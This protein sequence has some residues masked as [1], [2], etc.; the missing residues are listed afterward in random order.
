MP[1]KDLDA[2]WADF[3]QTTQLAA[4]T[5][6]DAAIEH[7]LRVIF[8][9]G[10]SAGLGVVTYYVAAGDDT[11]TLTGLI[12]QLLKAHDIIHADTCRTADATGAVT[13][14]EETLAA[15]QRIAQAPIPSGHL[16]PRRRRAT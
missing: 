5:G 1:F 12:G 9:A 10:A 16:P 2:A 11:L 7:Y 15:L 4:L 3:R 13:T 8:S 14:T 6:G